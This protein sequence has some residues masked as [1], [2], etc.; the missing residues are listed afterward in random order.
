MSTPSRHTP[1]IDMRANASRSAAAQDVTERKYSI[2]SQSLEGFG[3]LSL[4]EDDGDADEGDAG[5]VEGDGVL[6]DELSELAAF[7]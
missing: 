1:P 6:D 5:D 4:G 2:R 3:G 7:L